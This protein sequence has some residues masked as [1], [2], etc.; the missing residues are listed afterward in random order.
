[1]G[2]EVEASAECVCDHLQR[3]DHPDRE[4][5][6]AKV[7]SAVNQTVPHMA[8]RRNWL[9]DCIALE[10]ERLSE[11]ILDLGERLLREAGEVAVPAVGDFIVVEGDIRRLVIDLAADI[12]VVE[13]PTCLVLKGREV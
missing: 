3:P 13:W 7:R 11:M 8:V 10:P 6:N 5:T 12:F 2:N 1:M 9:A 4:L